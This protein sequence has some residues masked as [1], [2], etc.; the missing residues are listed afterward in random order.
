MLHDLTA[1]H[2]TKCWTTKIASAQQ[3]GDSLLSSFALL[4][5]EQKLPNY[6]GEHL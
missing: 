6:A 4:P 3:D 2:C 1:V 5:V